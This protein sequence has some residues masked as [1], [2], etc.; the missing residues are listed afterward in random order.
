[1]SVMSDL[2]LAV[3]V[4]PF[5][6]ATDS[7]VEGVAALMPAAYVE[8]GFAVECKKQQVDPVA[9]SDV[10]TVDVKADLKIDT[11]VKPVGLNVDTKNKY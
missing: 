4:M 3:P 9:L 2:V 11:V 1:M 7:F 10:K 6:T 8:L 5:S